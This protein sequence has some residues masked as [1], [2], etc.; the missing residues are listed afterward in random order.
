MHPNLEFSRNS[1]QMFGH[2]KF[3]SRWLCRKWW[4]PIRIQH[5]SPRQTHN[6]WRAVK[7]LRNQRQN[8]WQITLAQDKTLSPRTKSSW[9]AQAWAQK[10]NQIPTHT[11]TH[12]YFELAIIL[13]FPVFI[14]ISAK[15]LVFELLSFLWVWFFFF[16]FTFSFSFYWFP[17][18]SF[19]LFQLVA[20][21][22]FLICLF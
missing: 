18:S 4:A 16:W 15:C 17:V 9:Q 22:T 21:A 11:H 6:I 7:E 5:M 3:I 19:N 12:T 8:L 2:I 13:I 20:K 14:L 1:E 10:Q